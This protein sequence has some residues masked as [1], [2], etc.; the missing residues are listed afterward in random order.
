MKKIA[1]L[2]FMIL[3]AAGSLFALNVDIDLPGLPGGSSYTGGLDA[4]MAQFKAEAENILGMFDKMDNIVK[5]MANTGSYAS[6]GATTR[7]FLGYEWFTLG[8]GTMGALQLPSYNPDVEEFMNNIKDGENF[9]FGANAQALTVSGGVNLETLL[10]IEGLYVSGKVGTLSLNLYD[11]DVDTFSWGLFAQYQLV[12]PVSNLYI[13]WRGLQVGTG[14]VYYS[15]DISFS[16]NK[17]VIAGGVDTSAGTN[18]SLSLDNDMT[19][20]ASIRGI[21][22]PLDLMTGVRLGILDISFGLGIDINAWGTSEVSYK[23]SGPISIDV[24]GS[25]LGHVEIT[26]GTT[27]GGA[28]VFR[29]KAMGGVG[30]TLGPVKIDFP[31]TYY[32]DSKGPGANLGV[33][34]GFVW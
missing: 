1:L 29:F 4:P 23:I 32:F 20:K 27:G 16:M 17:V 19:V 28:D 30:L 11:F 13:A 6:D 9:Y 34:G 22:I 14:F 7:N 18:R 26:G 10:D 8:V 24:L 5:G 15:S 2:G 21:K 3:F 31:V 12:K 25:S 33:T